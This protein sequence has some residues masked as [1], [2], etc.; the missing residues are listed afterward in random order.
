ML[1]VTAQDFTTIPYL[2]PGLSEDSS[3]LVPFVEREEEEVLRRILGSPLYEKFVAQLALLPAEWDATTIYNTNV[4]TVYNGLLYKALQDNVTNVKPDSDAAKWQVQAANKWLELK[5]GKKYSLKNETKKYRWVG[6][7]KLFIRY[8]HAMWLRG[9]T[10][11]DFS[12]TGFSLS[13]LEN[14]ERI[15]PAIVISRHYNEFSEIVGD[16]DSLLDTLYGFLYSSGST[17]YSELSTDEDYGTIR[18]YLAARFEEPGMMNS[19]NL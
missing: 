5:Y 19:L 2:I 16:S 15:D 9:N 7:K 17:Y 18:E 1:F 3:A 11:G 6:M 8:I 10:E 4:Q 14:S 12:G 13:K